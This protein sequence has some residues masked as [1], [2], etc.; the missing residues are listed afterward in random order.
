M[1]R[2]DNDLLS[3]Q[4]ARIRMENA[5]E[6]Q[7]ALKEFSQEKLDAVICCIADALQEHLKD[8]AEHSCDETE[9]GNPADKYRKNAFVSRELPRKLAQMKCVGIISENKEEQTMDIG[10]PSGVIVALPPATS[11]VSTTIYKCLI[12]VKSGNA[13]VFSAHPRAKNVIAGVLEVMI[14]AA[15]GNGYPA[16]AISYLHTITPSGTE[17]L[18]SH[19]DTAQI[20]ITGVPKMYP[21]ALKAGKP[22]LYGGS[23][24]GPVFIE[25]TADIRKAARDIVASRTFDCGIVSAAEQSI[26][27]DGCAAEEIRRELVCAGAYFMNEEESER[28]IRLFEEPDGVRDVVGK[29]ALQLAGYAGF[30]VPDGT[31]V[32]ISEQKY[33]SSTNPFSYERLCPVMAFYVENDWMHA[34]EKCIELLVSESRAHTLVIHSRDESV[35]REFAVKKPVSRV[36]VNTPAV[37]GSMGFTTN[38]FPAM[39]LGSG[40]AGSGVTSDNVSPMNLIHIRKVGYGVRGVGECAGTEKGKPAVCHRESGENTDY[41]ENFIHRFQNE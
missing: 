10:V 9:Y 25:R 11:P 30:R 28:L 24:N 12:A 14:Q 39:T 29:T 5:R 26:V 7:K 13:I 8:L 20:L 17:A 19:P 31:K 22:V 1:Y 35:I 37:F 6:A 34:C 23:G 36:L 4:E 32:L 33:V 16:G 27:A 15:E 38:L 3:V 40:S 41:I 21:K 18:F 2:I